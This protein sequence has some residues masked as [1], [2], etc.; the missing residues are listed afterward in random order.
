MWPLYGC[1]EAEGYDARTWGYPSIGQ[2]LE[3]L[4]PPFRQELERLDGDPA[5]T[6]IHIVGHSLGGIIARYVL[7]RGVPSKMGRLVQLAPPN[8]GSAAARKTAS[9]WGGLFPVLDELSDA[10][11]SAVR[12]LPALDGVEVGV[13]AAAGDN[14]VRLGDT[15]L[16][17]EADHIVM[18][19]AHSVIML[20]RETCRQTI[21]FLRT[22]RFERTDEYEDPDESSSPATPP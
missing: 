6:R 2:R 3:T 5:V 17:G 21:H 12:E 22:G 7:S 14:R 16:S 9:A 10:P 1:L 18:P 8:Q 20:R 13:I 11:D 19:G 15:H 4:G